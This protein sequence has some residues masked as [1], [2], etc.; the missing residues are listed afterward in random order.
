MPKFGGSG[1]ADIHGPEVD[2]D[3]KLKGGISADVDVPHLKSKVEGPDVDVSAKL[4]SGNVHINAPHVVKKKD[5][6]EDSDSDDD[7]EK[8]KK[9]RRQRQVWIRIWNEDAKFGGSGK[10]DIHGPE[11]DVDGKL[12]GG[13]SADVDVPHLKSKVE[14]PDVDVSAK[15][16]SGN[17]DI[18]VRTKGSLPGIDVKGGFGL[19]V[20]GKKKKDT[21]EDSDS[22]DDSEKGK[23]KKDK[24]KSGSHSMKMPKF[25]GSGKADIHGP[26]VDVDGKLKGG[27]SAD[28]DVP[29]LKSK[30][31]G[32]DVDVSAKLPSGNVDINA[33]HGKGSIPGIDVKGGFGLNVS[34]KKKNRLRRL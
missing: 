33:P 12:K 11:V 26:E 25:G 31:E 21:G 27:I 18:N 20:S 22:Y 34:G 10:A 14:G 19:T 2:V 23:K 32:P 5:T 13:I 24:D 7:S 15:L 3:G 16:P 4:P 17:V 8:G 9:E 1:K 28:V 29:H 6:G 30:V